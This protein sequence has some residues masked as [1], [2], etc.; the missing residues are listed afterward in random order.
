M[1]I[2]SEFRLAKTEIREEAVV[3]GKAA[4]IAGS[5]AVLALY[6]GGFLLLACVYALQLVVAAWLAALIVTV[7]AART[8][9]I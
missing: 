6:A 4:T 8:L 5:G 9:V 1:D 7:G 3:A 2:R